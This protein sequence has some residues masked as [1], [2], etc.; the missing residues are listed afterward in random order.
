MAVARIKISDDED[1]VLSILH[2]HGPMRFTTAADLTACERL[3]KLAYIEDYGGADVK[4]LT[5]RGLR[6]LNK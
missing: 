5:Q 4:H 1:T 3:T 6:Y 2:D